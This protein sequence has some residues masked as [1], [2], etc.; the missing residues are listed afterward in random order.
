MCTKPRLPIVVLVTVLLTSPLWGATITVTS[1]ADSGAGTLRAAIDTANGAA[2]ADSIVFAADLA[3]K[4]IS[5]QSDLP[6]ITDDATTIIGDI[7]SDGKPDI[8]LN[9]SSASINAGLAIASAGNVIRGLCIGGCSYGINISGSDAHDNSIRSCYLGTNLAGTAPVPNEN[10]GLYI[11]YAAD[12]VIGGTTAA[13]RNVIS[14]N[15]SNG[16]YLYRARNTTISSLYCGLNAAGTGRL[17]NLSYGLNASYCPGLQLGAAVAGLRT[18]IS[19]NYSYGAYVQYSPGVKVVN[20]FAGTNAGGGAA[21]PNNGNGLYLSGCHNAVIG[22]LVANTANVLSGNYG[23]G[24]YASSCVNGPQVVGNFVGTNLAGTAAVP[25]TSSALNLNSCDGAQVGGNV[26]AARNV[27]SGNDSDGVYL[28]QCY[29]LGV[30]G[31]YIGVDKTGLKELRNSGD[32]VEANQCCDLVIGGTTAAERN[33]IVCE[34]NGLYISGP[35]SNGTTARG[36]YIGYA[37]DGGTAFPVYTGVYLGYGAR[38]AAIGASGGGNRILATYAGVNLYR[39]GG[40]CRVAANRIGAPVGSTPYGNYGIQ[41]YNCTAALDGNSVLQQSSAGLYVSG[42][43]AAPVVT[44]NQF[45]R[46]ARGVNIS[47]LAAPNLGDLTTPSTADNGNNTFVG[48][49]DYD[50]HNSTANPIRAEGNTFA[51]TKAEQI[52]ARFIYDQLDSPTLGRVDYSPLKSGPPTAPGGAGMIALSA[53]P[54]RGGGAQIQVQLASTAS[55]QAEVLNVAGRPIRI[56]PEK[57]AAAGSCTLLWD[58][59]SGSGTVVP[60][61]SYLVGVRALGCDGTQQRLLTRLQISR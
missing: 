24:L 32:G 39:A 12:N 30:V 54:T 17:G 43:R 46:N 27:I 59:R 47:D 49:S 58:G 52:D 22:G 4:S 6:N 7:N 23:S 44:N 18:V 21:L 28:S 2:G 5:L 33:I 1:Q 57:T 16:I 53:L 42:N 34:N 15:Y 36:N 25:N 26:A 13:A 11:S 14:G 10:Y 31:N 8:M 45:R 41:V 3:G 35:L 40:G 48:N 61:G 9:G 29:G 50:I 55:L 19:G 56:L 38:N 51:S 60:A 37:S 20:T